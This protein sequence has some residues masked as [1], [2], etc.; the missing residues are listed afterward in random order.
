MP[1]AKR[2]FYDFYQI[3]FGPL[4]LAGRVKLGEKAAKVFAADGSFRKAMASGR[5]KAALAAG[6]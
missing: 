4:P 2:Y 3:N 5:G 1:N 6:E